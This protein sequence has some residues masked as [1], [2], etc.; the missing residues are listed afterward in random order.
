MYII[1]IKTGQQ[2]SPPLKLETISRPLARS[3]R[4][5]CLANKLECEVTEEVK[6]R[7]VKFKGV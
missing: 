5:L 3:C 2:G 6:P 1:T 7:P 4:I